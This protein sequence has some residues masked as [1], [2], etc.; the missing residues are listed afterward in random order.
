MVK[1]QLA[2]N[3]NIYDDILRVTTS[4]KHCRSSTLR[5]PVDRIDVAPEVVADM[6]TVDLSGFKDVNMD[7]LIKFIANKQIRILQLNDTNLSDRDIIKL[8]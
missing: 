6:H 3:K 1:E 2:L 7:A 4:C 5:Q 8:A